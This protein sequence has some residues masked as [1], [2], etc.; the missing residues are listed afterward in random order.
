MQSNEIGSSIDFKLY[1]SD[2]FMFHIRRLVQHKLK[3][4]TDFEYFWDFD[5]QWQL[6]PKYVVRSRQSSNSFKIPNIFSLPA[7]IK[8]ID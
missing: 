4:Q 1:N 7:S 3:L 8:R 5:A 2:T 6:N